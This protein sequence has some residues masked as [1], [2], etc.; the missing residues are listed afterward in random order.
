[1]T[2][3]TK[4]SVEALS[5]AIA[6]DSHGYVLEYQQNCR[7]LNCE[8]VAQHS[9]GQ[10]LHVMMSRQQRPFS[11]AESGRLYTALCSNCGNETLFLNG[12]I[13]HPKAQDAP[14]PSP[15][16]PD[17]VRA[18][19]NE[20]S[21][22]LFASPRGAAA[23][24]RLAVQKL[25]PIIGAT[26][27]SI[28]GGIAELVEKRRISKEVKEALDGVRICG[29][30]AVHPGELNLDDDV[31]T[32]TALFGLINYIVEITLTADKRL[33]SVT[34]KIPPKKAQGIADRDRGIARKQAEA[35]AMPSA[36]GTTAS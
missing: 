34:A 17:V 21:S 23:L 2:F 25:L 20:A 14:S 3:F 36:N 18:D 26:N 11:S 28:D 16:M 29:N 15:D 32:V 4:T 27:L 12:V 6:G 22:I 19:Y 8:V 33:A 35:E 24:L 10:V 7:C 1:M 5:E 31:E 13:I 30:E 9:F